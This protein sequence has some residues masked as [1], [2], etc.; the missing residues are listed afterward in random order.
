MSVDE[1][2]RLH[3]KP[4]RSPNHSPSK[5]LPTATSLHPP[6]NVSLQQHFQQDPHTLQIQDKVFRC[7]DSLLNQQQR[8]PQSMFDVPYS[9]Q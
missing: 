2:L 9:A 4:R 1:I 7:L 5:S 6:L 8:A 3:Q